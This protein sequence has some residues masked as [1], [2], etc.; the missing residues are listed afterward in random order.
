VQ[1]IAISM[2][3]CLSTDL[4]VRS[5]ISK[6]ASAD[7]AKFS[8]CYLWPWLGPPLMTVICNV[9]A[10]Q[11]ITLFFNVVG[12]IQIQAW[13]L[14]S[15]KLFTMTRQVAA[16]K[17]SF[18]GEVCCRRLPRLILHLCLRFRRGDRVGN[19]PNSRVGLLNIF[20]FHN[21]NGGL[22]M[23]KMICPAILEC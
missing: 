5:H 18:E 11:R 7:L 20:H 13:S 19:F 22:Q 4:P 8:V 16:L 3:V 12:Q 1:S 14:R 10:V 6:T 23:T 21:H 17:C 15:S 2:S 9:L